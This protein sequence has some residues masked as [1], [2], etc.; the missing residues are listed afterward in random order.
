MT[1]S[2]KSQAKKVILVGTFW[3]PLSLSVANAAE[4]SVPATATSPHVV[5]ELKVLQVQ[6]GGTLKEVK[7]ARPGDTLEYALSYRNAGSGV[8]RDMQATLPI[9]TGTHFTGTFTGAGTL[10]ASTDGRTF[11]A[12]PIMRKLKQAN[13]QWLETAVPL[14]QY[15]AVRWPARELAAGEHW[16]PTARVQ[17]ARISDR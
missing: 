17:V 4:R 16:R 13:G 14:S 10:L 5:S 15:R 12:H 6:G 3:I 8:A 1:T 11:E 2:F 7:E 9:P